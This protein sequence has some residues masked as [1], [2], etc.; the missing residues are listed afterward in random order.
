MG[1]EGRALIVQANA[2]RLPL[3]DECVDLAIFSPPYW[4]L[5]RYDVEGIGNEASPLAWLEALW[6]A[7]A[8]VKR[9]LKPSGSIFVNL[10]DKYANDSIPGARS[11][12]PQGGRPGQ[13]PSAMH[14][15]AKQMPRV[16]TPHDGVR[17]KSLL[18]LPGLYAAGCSGMLAAIGGPDP[19]LN[20]IWRRDQIWAKV[21]HLPESVKDRTASSH[22]YIFH[23]TKQPRYYAALDTLRE[24]QSDRE[25]HERYGGRYGRRDAADPNGN[26]HTALGGVNPL[27]KLPGSVW[28]IASDPL[29]LPDYL[30]RDSNG[31]WMGDGAAL[32]QHAARHGPGVIVEPM[33]HYAAYPPALVR[34]I[35]LGWSPPGIC[36]ECDQGR[37]PVVDRQLQRSERPGMVTALTNGHGQDGRE[38]GRHSSE[39]TILGWACSCFPPGTRVVMA[40]GTRRPIEAVQAGDLVLTHPGNAK[41][42]LSTMRRPYQGPLVALAVEGLNGVTIRATPEH[43]FYTANKD[44][45]L[46][47]S[48]APT[49]LAHAGSKRLDRLVPQVGWQNAEDLSVG[50]FVST[51]IPAEEIPVV[52]RYRLAPPRQHTAWRK[53]NGWYSQF[54]IDRQKQRIYA[55]TRDEALAKVEAAYERACWREVKVDTNLAHLLGW[56]IAEG[57]IDKRNRTVTTFDLGPQEASVAHQLAEIGRAQFGASSNIQQRRTGIR[58][59]IGSYALRQVVEALVGTGS[60]TKRL[61]A[62]LLTLPRE[63]QGALLAGWML[64]DGYQ[65]KPW[66]HVG[67]SAS[68]GLIDQLQI[69]AERLGWPV[70]RRTR[71]DNAGG[72]ESTRNAG[73][74][75]VLAFNPEPVAESMRKFAKDGM[76]WRRILSLAEEPYDGEVFNLEVEGDNSYQVEGVNVHNCTP[77]TLHPGTGESSGPDGRYAAALA[78]GAYPN[79]GQGWGGKG[80]LGDRPKVGTWREFHLDRWQPPPTRPAIVLDPFSGVG[81]TVMVARALGRIGIGTDLS[82]AYS[83]AG[84]WRAHHSGEWQQVI[85][86]TT[87]RK[88]RPLPKHDPAQ[89]RLAL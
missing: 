39:A 64:G 67:V 73:P 82:F 45:R 69:I 44:Y 32:W 76:T 8:E 72:L 40:D 12:I 52:V 23:L 21:N 89:E 57:S 80:G 53:G 3:P 1:S 6:A 28:P 81:T 30:V 70:A 5:R 48:S 56:Y 15:S 17:A 41:R 50:R 2:L 11:T 22:E 7:T 68:E 60:H 78:D 42:V 14:R 49:R 54:F 9:V 51:G 71:L 31:S 84:H 19:G 55:R 63:E 83:R 62:S 74:L 36:V 65:A 86:R 25:H 37:W 47:D 59:T 58:L 16:K 29:R 13:K 4:N 20:L 79:T 34:R 77:S 85:E 26:G 38:G 24:P 43:P 75:Y 10:G 66:R 61:D 88:A 18:G 46:V 35:I 87:G 27:G 33:A